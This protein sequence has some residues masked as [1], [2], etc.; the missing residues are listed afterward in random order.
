MLRAYWNVLAPVGELQ[1]V[2]LDLVA[3][4][5][6]AG[7]TST[8][9]WIASNP[10]WFPLGERYDDLNAYYEEARRLALGALQ[11]AGW[12]ASEPLLT[13]EVASEA[14]L[15]R[16]RGEQTSPRPLQ[17]KGDGL[18]QSAKGASLLLVEAPMG[19]GKTELA[20]LAHLRLQAANGHRG[21]YVALPTQATGN[22]LFKRTMHFLEAFVESQTDIQLVHGGAAM[23]EN[24]RHL[25]G[26]G[27]SHEEALSASAWFSQRRRPLL[28]A[29]G[30]GTVDQA[31]LATL[32]VKHHFVRLW[33]LGNRVVV[34]DEV[35]AYD[36]YTSGL[37]V[38]LLRWLKAMGSSVVLMS[39]TLPRRMRDE[40]ITA[41]DASP[42]DVPEQSYPRATLVDDS[43]PRSEHVPARPLDPIECRALDE[44]LDT[45]AAQASSLVVEGGCGA[46][47]VNTV[48]RAQKLYGMLKAARNDPGHPDIDDDLQLVLCHA[49]FPADE[50]SVR[51]S[52]VL[53]MFGGAAETR[54]VAALLVATQVAEQSLDLDFDFMLS[55]LAPID[56]I[57]QRAGRMHRH[58]R[59]RP[60]KHDRPRLWI[61]G[62]TPDRLPSLKDTAWGYV[63]DPY[64][65]ARTW[66][67]LRDEAVLNLP[68]DID[69]LVQTV[70]GDTEIPENLDEQIRAFIEEEAYGDHLGIEQSKRQQAVNISIDIEAE[71]Q[72]AYHDKP[73]G[74]DDEMG[75]R[76]QTRLGPDSVSV[77][78]VTI[79]E[80]GWRIGD[81]V[82]DPD[83]VL[84]DAT[85]QKLY[86]RQLRLSRKAVV[87][88]CQQSE[89]SPSFEQHPI[90]KHLYPLPLTEAG[91][92]ETGGQA[93]R[94]DA[95]F[96][97]VYVETE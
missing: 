44:S 71:P 64:I 69:R 73:F 49:R 59:R 53:E 2:E 42:S 83:C 90:L 34:L 27:H 84:D 63:Y 9:D 7:L 33:G 87:V 61:A 46:I 41:W 23:N 13:H 93:M 80:N 20:F 72:N 32:N 6:L 58:E 19:E 75:M 67:F 94:L 96:G 92:C 14:L 78:P 28:S 66:A 30:V 38:S 3:V 82:F 77:V 47:I 51:E 89:L 79:T 35:H 31:L 5:W 4:N 43:K 56:L 76:N 70:Y 29:Y 36:T 11:S 57:L 25:R 52:Q 37:I 18:L 74:G 60:T 40:L 88:H 15:T 17:A 48:D 12:T 50:R 95:E 21:L 10:A 1:S 97:L 8:A 16:I 65:L 39:A 68:G 54:P 24:V 55:D 91:N 85:A 81:T 26:I 22:A 62:L 86:R 45:I